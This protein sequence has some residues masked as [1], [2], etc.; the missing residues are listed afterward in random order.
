MSS[1]L[2]ARGSWKPAGQ[3]SAECGRPKENGMFCFR[4][5]VPSN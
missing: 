5:R 3:P 1:G 2:V 4:M